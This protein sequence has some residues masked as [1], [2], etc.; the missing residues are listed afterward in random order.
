MKNMHILLVDDEEGFITTLSERLSLRGFDNTAVLNGYLAL[1][2]CK[3]QQTDIVV[4]DLKMPGMNGME[5]L[6]ELQK[7]NKEARIIIQSGH[8]TDK[9]EEEAAQLGATTFLRKPVDIDLL[10]DAIKEAAQ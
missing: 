6:R 4:L 3:A 8:V 10:I 2:H 1:E 9:E 5:V 7:I